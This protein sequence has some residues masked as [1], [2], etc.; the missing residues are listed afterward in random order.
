MEFAM[1]G[2]PRRRARRAFTLVELLVVIAIIGILVALLLPAVQA[3]REAGR[4]MSCSNNLKQIG[5]AIH[6][7]HDTK[8]VFPIDV[9][10]NPVTRDRRGQFSNKVMMLPYLEANTNFDR[11]DEN[12]HPWNPQGWGPNVAVNRV[13]HSPRLSVFVCPSNPHESRYGAPKGFGNFTYS[14]NIGTNP[15]TRSDGKHDGFASFQ[16]TGF[17]VDQLL[18]FKN[19]NDG[20]SNTVAYA[21]IMIDSGEDNRNA[22]LFKGATVMNWVNCSN[23]VDCRQKC[24]DNW[25]TRNIIGGSRQGMRGSAWAWSFMGA[26]STYTHTMAPNE[27]SCHNRNSTDWGGNSMMA[28]GSAHPGG[29]KVLLADGSVRFIQDTIDYTAWLAIGTRNGGEVVQLPD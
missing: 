10:W 5:I 1:R 24:V 15:T 23:P 2:H 4:R 11:T 29:V 16:G 9:G 7:Y 20:A 8:K 13:A 14:I 28:A 12:G 21:E 19:L 26:G 17:P 25:N 18:G 3:A 22:R 27:P 6:N